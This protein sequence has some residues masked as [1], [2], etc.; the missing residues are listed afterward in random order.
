[1]RNPKLY[2]GHSLAR[3]PPRSRMP[4]VSF[5][6]AWARMG[7]TACRGSPCASPTRFAPFAS[8]CTH[9]C[10]RMRGGANGQYTEI[11]PDVSIV[12]RWRWRSRRCRTSPP[13]SRTRAEASR[14]C[15]FWGRGRHCRTSGERRKSRGDRAIVPERS[16]CAA[17][18]RSG[19]ADSKPGN[20]R[21]RRREGER[22]LRNQE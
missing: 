6:L 4:L 3:P 11:K 17:W 20:D 14:R 10:R 7:P 15:S 9:R 13:R 5:S 8:D 16:A 1:M 12:E 22:A 21:G 18:R 2:Q 19:R